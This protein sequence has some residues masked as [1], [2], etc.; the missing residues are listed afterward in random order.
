MLYAPPKGEESTE[1]GSSAASTSVPSTRLLLKA[2]TNNFK[3]KSES[4]SA[5]RRK[6]YGTH[7]SAGS[8]RLW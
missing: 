5:A 2:K 6:V 4:G 1:F 7:T 3:Q 8:E